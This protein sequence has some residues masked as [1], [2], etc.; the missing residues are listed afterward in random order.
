METQT[1]DHQGEQLCGAVL[2]IIMLA[3]GALTM[4]GLF[5]LMVLSAA[6]I[7]AQVFGAA[8]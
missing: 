7:V 2:G 4:V 5:F 1:N 3:I 6:S 8:L